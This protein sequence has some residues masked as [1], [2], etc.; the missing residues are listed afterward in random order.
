MS[1]PIIELDKVALTLNGRTVLHDISL[2][3]KE[4]EFVAILGPNGA[5]KSTLLKLLLGLYKPTAGTIS[6]LG[7][8]PRRGNNEIGYAPQHRTLEADLALRARDIVGFGLDGNHWGIAFPNKKREKHIDQALEEVDMLRLANVPVG[9]LSGGE[10]QRLLIAQALLTH[11]KILLLDEPLS[12]LDII[13]AEGIVSLINKIARNRKM[14]VLL[15]THDVNILLPIIDRVLYMANTH[16]AIGKPEEV[17]T[18][19]NLTQ[20]YGS[21]VEVIKAQGRLFVIGEET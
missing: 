17:I 4:G 6:V 2:T 19:A 21:P 20:L 9:E 18:N 16:S 1:T 13:H 12:N 15:V 14:T 11:P 5:G 10:Q 7:K 3:I 8:S